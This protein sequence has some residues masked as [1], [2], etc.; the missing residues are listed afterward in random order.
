VARE[1]GAAVTHPGLEFDD[2]RRG[3]LLAQVAARVYRFAAQIALNLEHAVDALH[4]FQG[5]WR[6]VG[7]AFAA[8]GIGGDVGEFEEISPCMGP[9]ERPFERRWHAIRFEQRV[10]ARISVGLDNPGVA[11]QV[12]LRMFAAPVA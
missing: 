8:L 11:G 1:F 6:D 12:G 10:V 3:E 9:A 5:H 7:R 2:D 4:G